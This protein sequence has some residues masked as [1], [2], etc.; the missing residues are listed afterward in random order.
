MK[1][2]V[3]LFTFTDG[4]CAI[5]RSTQIGYAEISHY[6]SNEVLV[7]LSVRSESPSLHNL[8]NLMSWQTCRGSLTRTSTQ[9]PLQTQ[10]KVV[11]TQVAAMCTRCLY[12]KPI[13]AG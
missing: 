4:G 1:I 11:N 5:I 6:A 9:T 2:Y 13:I 7:D 8:R 10:Y 12:I 3:L